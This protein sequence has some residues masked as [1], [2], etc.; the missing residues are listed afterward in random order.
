MWPE[1]NRL[2]NRLFPPVVCLTCVCV[3]FF[4][5]FCFLSFF[6]DCFVEQG[7]H[8]SLIWCVCMCVCMCVYVCVYVCVCMCVCVCVK[9]VVGRACVAHVGP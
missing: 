8:L 6:I 2:F 4:F 1:H 3:S 7:S 5:P 9:E